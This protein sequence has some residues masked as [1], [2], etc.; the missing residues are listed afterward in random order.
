MQ[1]IYNNESL[2]KMMY[3]KY[4]N[5]K[6]VLLGKNQ[7]NQEQ[8]ELIPYEKFND[9]YICYQ[10]E[11][12]NKFLDLVANKWLEKEG[13]TKKMLRDIAKHNLQKM[14]FRI[15]TLIHSA[16]F[17]IEGER[18]YNNENLEE[19]TRYDHMYVLTDKYMELGASLLLNKEVLKRLSNHFESDLAIIPSSIHELIIVPLR[20]DV[21]VNIKELN[22]A[23]V[24]TNKSYLKN[25]EK[26]TN[27]V[28]KYTRNTNYITI[29]E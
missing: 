1:F 7:V 22:N 28:Y 12:N 11:D 20:S 8:L 2:K 19:L 25:N 9:L 6:F 21:Q 18:V 14:D 29:I 17:G 15:T 10:F 5:I 23:I 13:L 24:D 3:E 27:S 4:D 26:L 16:I